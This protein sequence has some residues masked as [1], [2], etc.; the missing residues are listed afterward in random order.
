MEKKIIHGFMIAC[1]LLLSA[2]SQGEE[3]AVVV[4]EEGSIRKIRLGSGP[5]SSPD[6][7]A[8]TFLCQS[9]LKYHTGPTV[10]CDTMVSQGSMHN[11]LAL[12]EGK[13]EFGIARADGIYRAW[14]GEPP[15]KN[16]FPE[17]RVLFALHQEIMTLVIPEAAKLSNLRAVQGKRIA[18]DSKDADNARVIL[19]LL[20][21]CAI[22]ADQ[23]VPYG[24]QKIDQLS[25]AFKEQSFDAFFALLNHPNDL[26][27]SVSQEQNFA[28]LPLSEDCVETMV[29]SRAFYDKGIIPGEIYPNVPTNIPSF[30]IR[31]WILASTEAPEETVYAMVKAVFEHIDEL[32]KIHPALHRLSP[33]EML[34]QFS[35]PYH[36]G[37]LK[38]F[39]EKGWFV[40]E[41]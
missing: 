5:L 22:E 18:F 41:R 4:E 15:F 16:S 23:T 24:D 33:R 35:V 3:K 14:Q 2:C 39:V 25:Q 6:Y 30:G 1:L 13:V 29:Q 38:Y 36:N 32:R 27:G 12:H 40:Q 37:A 20:K 28:I 19:D 11:L 17:L 8:A 10:P 21:A 26:L 7:A 34:P 31:S 9:F